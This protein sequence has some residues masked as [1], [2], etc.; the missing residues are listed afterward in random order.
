MD[1]QCTVIVMCLSLCT[2]WHVVFSVG[3]RSFNRLAK[4]DMISV[5]Y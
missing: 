4:Y 3:N 5:F 2:M 1:T